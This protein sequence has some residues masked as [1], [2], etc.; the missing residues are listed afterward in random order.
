MDKCAAYPRWRY[1]DIK[2]IQCCHYELTEHCLQAHRALQN[3]N[4]FKHEHYRQ[5]ALAVAVGIA[6]QA[7]VSLPVLLTKLSIRTAGLFMDLDAATWDDTVVSSLHFIQHSVL[8]VPFFLMNLLKFLNPA[9]DA[10]FMESLEWVDRTYMAKHQSDDPTDLRAMYYPN[11]KLWRADR[12]DKKPMD[13]LLAFLQRYGKKAG[14]SLTVLLLSY[15][16]YIGRFV[17]PALSFYYFRTAVGPKPAV[18]VFASG[19]VLPRRYLVRFL[20]MY[21]SS[22]TMM[23]ELL[24]PYFS[25]IAFAPEQ[26]R[27]WFRDREGVLFGFGVA[28]FT[29]V[30][31][32][33]IGVLVYGIAEASTAFLLTKITDPP[34][35]PSNEAIK[36]DYVESQVRWK[37]KNKFLTLDMADLDKLNVVMGRSGDERI[38]EREPPVKKFT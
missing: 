35:A 17:M 19:I 26:K 21:F 34:P 8:Q 5:A 18:A 31:I 20:Q 25:R 29:L 30:K 15:I 22:R 36:K 12:P 11:L 32:P 28:F 4:I 1:V 33:L 37:N 6:I 9:L 10:M 27:K 16:P 13:G 7:V 14:I 23:R 38:V 2:S 24:Q 3:P